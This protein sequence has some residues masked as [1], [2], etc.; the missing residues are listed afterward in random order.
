MSV[1]LTIAAVLLDAALG[2]PRRWHPLVGFGRWAQGWERLLNPREGKYASL[3]LRLQ[4]VLAVLIAVGPW[5]LLVAVVAVA[6]RTN[7]G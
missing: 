4:G 3:A 2:E 7:A 5:V 1:L 6:A